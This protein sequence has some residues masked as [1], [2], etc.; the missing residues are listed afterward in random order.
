MFRKALPWSSCR[1]RRPGLGEAKLLPGVQHG[2]DPPDT[3]A[4]DVDSS[5]DAEPRHALMHAAP[6][7]AYLLGVDREAASPDRLLQ[8]LTGGYSEASPLDLL[9]DGDARGEL[10]QIGRERDVVGIAGV[11]EL[12]LTGEP[13]QAPVEGGSDEVGKNGRGRSAL[14]QPVAI[15]GDLGAHRGRG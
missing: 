6:L 13:Q 7:D 15:G 11:G 14:R 3:L 2:A 8:R 1:G 4:L 12:V 9:V 5:V 10:R